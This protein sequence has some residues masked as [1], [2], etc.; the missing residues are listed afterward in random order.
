VPVACRRRPPAIRRRA[1]HVLFRCLGLDPSTAQAVSPGRKKLLRSTLNKIPDLA[2]PDLTWPTCS[3]CSRP[4]N[5]PRPRRV[6]LCCQFRIVSPSISN[7]QSPISSTPQS[8]SPANA[9][10]ANRLSPSVHNRRSTFSG[11][12][13]RHPSRD[14]T[15]FLNPRF[16]GLLLPVISTP[17]PAL[18]IPT[19]CCTC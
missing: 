5:Q 1:P 9:R 8:A 16:A 10:A 18:Y 7:L 3:L 15:V 14:P 11:T 2:G 6:R 12:T 13:L 19:A 17:A 4:Q